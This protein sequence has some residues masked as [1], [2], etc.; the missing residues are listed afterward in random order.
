VLKPNDRT[1]RK[2][3]S[4]GGSGG[5]GSSSSNFSVAEYTKLRR[6]RMSAVTGKRLKATLLLDK[7][8]A[9]RASY[10]IT[11]YALLSMTH[12]PSLSLQR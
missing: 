7:D 9:H 2:R 3:S 10:S 1:S 4:V 11:A 5:G 12:S 8:K 6:V